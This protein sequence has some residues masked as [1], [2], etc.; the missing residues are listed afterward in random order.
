M[1][2]GVVAGFH[3]KNDYKKHIIISAKCA[4]WLDLGRIEKA[5]K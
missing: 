2:G 3:I 4:L 5:N 1:K